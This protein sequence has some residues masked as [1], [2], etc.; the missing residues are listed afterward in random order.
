MTSE[1]RAEVVVTARMLQSG[2]FLQWIAGGL[3]AATA[4]ALLFNVGNLFPTIIALAAGAVAS[5]YAFR[6]ALD[7]RLFDDIANETL[8][9]D[10]LDHALAAIGKRTQKTRSWPDRCRGAR[11]LIARAAAATAVQLIAIVAAAMS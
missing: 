11:R 2:A 8:S 5:I 9:T 1:E 6:V 7:A 4:A 3:L 10:G